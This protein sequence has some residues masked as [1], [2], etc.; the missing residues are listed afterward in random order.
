MSKKT[1]KKQVRFRSLAKQVLQIAKDNWKLIGGIVG[2]YAAMYF[3]FAEGLTAIDI[4]T[5]RS[6][7]ETNL[8]IQTNTFGGQ[9]ILTTAVFEAA[10]SLSEVGSAYMFIIS[11]FTIL[12]LIWVLRHI[13]SKQ[14]TTIR[15]AFYKSMYPIVPFLLLTGIAI[16]QLIPLAIGSFVLTTGVQN[17]VFVGGIELFLAATVL[18]ALP[19]VWSFSMLLNTMFALIIIT[20]PDMAPM[21]AYAS[22][23]ELIKRRKSFVARHLIGWLLLLFAVFSLLI[24]ATIAVLPQAASIVGLIAAVL[25]LPAVTIFL[26]VLYRSLLDE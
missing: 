10:G 5:F 15:E 21:E 22:A 25:V 7:L 6:D 2:L 16:L 17:D 20:I 11:V 23:K 14:K 3:I 13:W 4:S 24:L 26:Y 18:L 19:A 1:A 12:A 9:L 8:G